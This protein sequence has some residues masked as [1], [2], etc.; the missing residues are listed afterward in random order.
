LAVGA[1][2]LIFRL[3]GTRFERITGQQAGRKGSS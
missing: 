1:D 3:D 2:G